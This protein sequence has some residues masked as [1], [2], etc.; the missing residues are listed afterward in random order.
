MR[1]AALVIAVFALVASV[2]HG[3]A[4]KP[5]F[6]IVS[7]TKFTSGVQRGDGPAKKISF[8]AVELDA[9]ITAKFNKAE[10]DALERVEEKFQT[11]LKDLQ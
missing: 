8:D 1:A 7:G 5:K 9:E 2:A 10:K 4:G 6:N 11:L 3:F